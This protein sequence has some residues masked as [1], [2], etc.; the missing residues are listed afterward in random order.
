MGFV[1]YARVSSTDQN[2]DAQVEA[3]KKADCIKIFAEKKAVHLKKNGPPLRSA[4]NISEK[5]IRLLS[6]ELTV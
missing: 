2:F 5:T 4:W 6:R 1:G 3:L